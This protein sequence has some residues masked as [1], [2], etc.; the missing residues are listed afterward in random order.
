MLWE[1]GKPPLIWTLHNHDF[2]TREDGGG[3]GG[4]GRVEVCRD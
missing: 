2:P 3:G 4:D 1:P